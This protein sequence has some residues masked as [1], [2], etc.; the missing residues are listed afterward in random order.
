MRARCGGTRLVPCSRAVPK[1]RTPISA[2]SCKRHPNNSGPPSAPRLLLV[3]EG[4]AFH[5]GPENLGK[6]AAPSR[7][8]NRSAFR[9]R[10]NPAAKSASHSRKSTGP[11]SLCQCACAISCGPIPQE[12]EE[13]RV[14]YLG[15]TGRSLYTEPGIRSLGRC[16][17]YQRKPLPF[18]GGVPTQ[19]SEK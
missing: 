19:S 3:R 5:D 17:L 10:E 6:S 1:P 11:V 4:P 16:A 2:Q 7:R 13:N 12:S 9:Q 8:H 15:S 14:L 18:L